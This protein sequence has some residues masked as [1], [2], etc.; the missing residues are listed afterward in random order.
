MF[1]PE[2]HLSH[3]NGNFN[4]AIKFVQSVAHHHNVVQI[5]LMSA[6]SDAIG[7]WYHVGHGHCNADQSYV[8]CHHWISIFQLH[9]KLLPLI[10]LIL[11]QLTNVS[12]FH[13]SHVV[14]SDVVA[15]QLRLLS[16]NDF[17]VFSVIFQ[18]AL[19]Y[20]YTNSSH[21]LGFVLAVKSEIFVFA[22]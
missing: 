1:Q 7:I 18:L 5:V 13:A 16:T 19:L 10:V 12:C 6:H 20:A 14:R 15:Y 9:N 8:G 4:D 2:Y 11:V 3:A 22:I 21:Q 17:I